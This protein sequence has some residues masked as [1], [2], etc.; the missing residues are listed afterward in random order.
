[1]TNNIYPEV[2]YMSLLSLITNLFTGCNNKEPDTPSRP[3]SFPEGTCLTEMYISHQGMAREP[4]YVLLTTDEGIVVRAVYDMPVIEVDEETQSK[5]LNREA[6]L[7]SE[8]AFG[9]TTPVDGA[10]VREL[11]DA[12]EQSG[13]LGW[14]ELFSKSY[15]IFQTLL[16]EE[17]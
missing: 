14:D 6:I 17:Y 15:D 8:E 9:E 2:I 4:Y 13:A 1:M 5:R 3:V 7:N 10:V 12:I 16:F 11:E